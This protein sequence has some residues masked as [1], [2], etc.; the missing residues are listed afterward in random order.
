[1]LGAATAAA[2]GLSAVASARPA[3]SP[4]ISAS[5]KSIAFGA[6]LT[7]QGSVPGA[8]AGEQV[9]I[10]GQVCGFTGAVPVGF[11]T[12]AVGGKFTY[13]MEPMLSATLFV[14]VGDAT[15]PRVE[16]RVS[17]G[18]QLRRISAGMFGIDVSSGNGAWFTK[19]ATLQRLD[20]RT[21]KWRR[22][23]AAPLKANSDPGALVAV[24]SATLHASVKRGTQLRAVVPQSTV[25][26]C[27]LPAVSPTLTA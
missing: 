23:G 21:K 6:N 24:S 9:Q 26:A 3:A 27:Y 25:G 12:T 17:P 19:S 7:L 11:A 2:A 8:A 13:S 10:M 4:T 1:M 20:P 14:Q 15:S 22:V 16:I 18:V 5:A